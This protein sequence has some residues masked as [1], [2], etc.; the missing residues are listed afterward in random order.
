M[1][2]V[3]YAAD[4]VCPMSGPPLPHG[5]V[6][7][8]GRRIVDVGAVADLAPRATR[9][10]EVH[11]VLLPGLVNAHTALEYTDA[12][13]LAVPGPAHAWLRALEGMTGSWSDE[14]WSR[15]AYRGVQQ[16]LRAGSTTVGDVVRRGPAVPAASRAGL[17]GDSW[18]QVTMVDVEHAD[19]VAAQVEHAL[20]LPAKGRRV[21][22][23]PHSPSLLGT[24]VLQALAALA[25]RMAAPLHVEAAET[26]GEVAALRSGEGPLAAWAREHAYAFEWLDGGT[27]LSPM[28]YLDACGALGPHTSVVHAVFADVLEARLLADRGAS[29]VC[30]PRAN[31]LRSAG[32][33]P[34]ERYADAGVRLALGTGSTASVPDLDLLAE[35]AAW[36]ALARRREMMFWPS[37]VGPITLEEQAIRLATVDGAW[38][39]GWGGQAGV[40]EPGRSADLLG[41]EITTK[42]ETAYRDLVEQG[43]GRQVLTV[44][45]GVRTARRSSADEPWPEIDPA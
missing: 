7:V 13:V 29:V 40:L 19:S 10:H 26:Q 18:V 34:L 15:S 9:I 28:R 12:A 6:L 27:D 32:D 37:S 16:A 1:P 30:C 17:A 41:V 33:A 8:E 4:V 2:A 23:A 39:M 21:G 14:A 43:P 36:V 5:G 44:L 38:A 11:G 22:I 45:A 42:P 25:Q 3:L 20:G 24:G 35:A 31:T